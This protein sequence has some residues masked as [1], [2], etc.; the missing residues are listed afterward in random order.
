MKTKKN[1][2]ISQ[3][4][5]PITPIYILSYLLMSEDVW[6]V[7]FGGVFAYILAPSVL[8]TRQMET[9]GIVLIYVMLIC[10][11]WWIAG[12]PSKKLTQVMMSWVR[13]KSNQK[14]T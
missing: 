4:K 13:K 1:S 3:R 7:V 6:R 9:A 14:T 11:G 2:G 10:I 12:Y 5:H 8:A